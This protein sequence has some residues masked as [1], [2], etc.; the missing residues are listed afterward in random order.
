MLGMTTLMDDTTE[1]ALAACD[2]AIIEA[3]IVYPN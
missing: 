2:T 3:H 1:K